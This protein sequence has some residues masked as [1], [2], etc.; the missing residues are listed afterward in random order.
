VFEGGPARDPPPRGPMA[1]N[2]AILTDKLKKLNSTQQAIQTL[3]HWVSYHKKYYLEIV[4]IWQREIQAV[5]DVG[6]GRGAR[7]P[8]SGGHHQWRSW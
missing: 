6:G 2:D 4:R 3:S 8:G 7:G 5:C 1:F